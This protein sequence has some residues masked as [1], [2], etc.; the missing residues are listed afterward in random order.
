MEVRLV[1]YPAGAINPSHT[2]PCAHGMYVLEGTLRIRLREPAELVLLGPGETRTIRPRRPH[3][4]SNAG[5][6][7]ATFFV[8]Q[9]VG[10]PDFVP[11]DDA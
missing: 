10:D 1:R 8:L 5:E 7:A 6:G 3:Q 9:G 11:A 4:V 2:H